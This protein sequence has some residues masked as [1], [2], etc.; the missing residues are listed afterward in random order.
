MCFV[1]QR[2]I[3][4]YIYFKRSY[5]LK[6]PGIK[7]H[8]A[9]I[10]SNLNGRSPRNFILTVSIVFEIFAASLFFYNILLLVKSKR[11][12]PFST[13]VW[14]TFYSAPDTTVWRQFKGQLLYNLKVISKGN[15]SKYFE[16]L[17]D[18]VLLLNVMK[19]WDE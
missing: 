17:Q 1:F 7:V 9:Y 11:F 16:K 6:N 5:D 14:A 10:S 4:W 3:K 15:F 18:G 8:V 2:T 19:C 12:P 13:E